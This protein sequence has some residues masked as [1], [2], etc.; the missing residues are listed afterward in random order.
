MLSRCTSRPLS[1][2][3]TIPTALYPLACSFNNLLSS[4]SR[5]HSTSNTSSLP[6]TK[7]THNGRSN[8]SSSESSSSPR[9]LSGG[10]LKT[11]LIE[12]LSRSRPRQ[13]LDLFLDHLEHPHQSH[14]G[15]TLEGLV[16]I[17]L[18]YRQP[19]LGLEAIDKM[20]KKGYQISSAMA[21]KLLRSYGN[22][23][24]FDGENLVKVLNWIKQG[25]RNNDDGKGGGKVDEEMVETVIQVLKNM[26]RIDW[27]AQ[28]FQ[29]YRE[30][31]EEGTIGNA[32]LW[33]AAISA[34][35]AGGDV[36]AA[37]LLFKDWRTRYLEVHSDSLPPPEQPYLALLNHF[38]VN[39][40]PMPASK[41][42]AYLLLQLTKLDRLPPSTAFLNALLRTELARK[43]FSSFWG[44]WNLFD[45]GTNLDQ[46]TFRDHSSWKLATR[47][48]LVSDELRRKRGRIHHS[49]LLNLSPLPY[50]ETLTPTSRSLFSNLLSTRLELTSHRPSL[51]LSTSQRLDPFAASPTSSQSPSTS[52]TSPLSVSVEASATL[53]NHFLSLFLSYQDFTAAIVVLETFHVHKISPNSST[54]ST[55]VLSII[56]LWEKGKLLPNYSRGTGGRGGG[57]QDG[58]LLTLFGEGTLGG[59]EGWERNRQRRVSKNFKGDLAIE[60][61]RRILESRKFRVGLWQRDYYNDDSSRMRMGGEEESEEVGGVSG[62]E[63]PKWMLQREMRDTSYLVDLLKRCSGLEEEEWQLALAKTRKELL[64]PSK[65]KKEGS[66]GA[67]REEETSAAHRSASKKRITRGARYRKERF[68]KDF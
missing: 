68:G 6:A 2:A 37:Q 11:L 52:T 58:E 65:K 46:G 32:K 31:L 23:L 30:S 62:E 44:I 39:S 36:M 29:A 51:R 16:W 3:Y 66:K 8:L 48:K 53:L 64:P 27:S 4:S 26:G 1:I 21:T 33:A 56:K 57:E 55:V 10:K 49:P 24:L 40:P 43:R 38:A 47:A 45:D 15:R 25:I 34:Q 12:H 5:P 35:A 7:D 13:A 63:P 54:H 67:R 17:F 14:S 19:R 42:P 20:H 22:E 9:T 59:I 61:I 18:S 41:D 28:V 50:S 60:A